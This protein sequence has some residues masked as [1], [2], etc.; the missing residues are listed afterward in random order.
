MRDNNG[1]SYQDYDRYHKYCSSRLKTIR[2][3]LK[4]HGGMK[5]KSYAYRKPSL[6]IINDKRYLELPLVMAERCFA[7]ASLLKNDPGHYSKVRVVKHIRSKLAKAVK[8]SERFNQ[9]CTLDLCTFNTFV[10]SKIYLYQANGNLDLEKMDFKS[11]CDNF[12]IAK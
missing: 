2:Q 9:L 3:K 10:E 11:A 1:V 5:A 8:Y 4:F 7:I 12:A 6:D